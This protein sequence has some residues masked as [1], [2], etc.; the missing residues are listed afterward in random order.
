MNLQ[1]TIA[2]TARRLE[3]TFS[4]SEGRFRELSAQLVTDLAMA[5]GEPGYDEALIAARDTLALAAGITAVDMGDAADAELRGVIF[6]FLAA[7][8]GL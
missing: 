8:G 7:A 3:V 6:G 5:F 1:E 2:A 4:G